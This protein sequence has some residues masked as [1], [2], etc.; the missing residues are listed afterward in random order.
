MGSSGLKPSLPTDQAGPHISFSSQAN[1]GSDTTR[2]SCGPALGAFPPSRP[3]FSKRWRPTQIVDAVTL[4]GSYNVS[5]KTCAHRNTV[6]GLIT[7]RLAAIGASNIPAGARE[8]IEADAWRACTRAVQRS[9]TGPR[10]GK[11]VARALAASAAVSAEGR[12]GDAES[13]LPSRWSGPKAQNT[14]TGHIHGHVDAGAVGGVDNSA[15]HR[16]H[17]A[18]SREYGRGWS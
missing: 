13:P 5:M 10:V 12:K 1:A 2:S 3:S 16:W 14:V 18:E 17:P 7:E 9:I 4:P 6:G 11:A 8:L 15:R